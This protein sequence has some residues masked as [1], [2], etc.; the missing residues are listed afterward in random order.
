MGMSDDV[1]TELRRIRREDA[2]RRHRRNTWLAVLAVMAVVVGVLYVW[3]SAEADRVNS[4]H[5]DTV[6]LS[7]LLDD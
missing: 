1:V 7:R 6:E 4:R 3:G 5:A 2:A